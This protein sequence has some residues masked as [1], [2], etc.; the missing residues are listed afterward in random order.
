MPPISATSIS[1]AN[2]VVL[3]MSIAAVDAVA[4]LVAA[5]LVADRGANVAFVVVANEPGDGSVI[6]DEVV[7][8]AFVV[9]VASMLGE[10]NGVG[11]G[12]G[13]GVCAVVGGCGVGRSHVHVDGAV[14]QSNAFPSPYF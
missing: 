7:L 14:P 8:L 13:L 3:T 6:P 9:V 4:S 12:V 5:T 10:L 1:G 2:N 11:F